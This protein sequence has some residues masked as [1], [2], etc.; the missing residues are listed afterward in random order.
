MR[1]DHQNDDAVALRDERAMAQKIV[2]RRRCRDDR[3]ELLQDS[4]LLAERS[5]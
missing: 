5:A 4:V 1:S 2:V 3:D